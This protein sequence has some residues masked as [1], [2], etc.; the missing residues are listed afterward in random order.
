FP[1]LGL[2]LTD[3]TLA[4]ADTP[5]KPF[6]D[7]RM[8][9]LSV[10]VMPLLRKEVQMSDIRV[11]GLNLNLQRDDKGHGNWEGVGRPTQASAPQPAPSEPAPSEDTPPSQPSEKPAG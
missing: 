11:D 8:I 3:A 2:E 5:D 9:G 7:L 1:W 4:S 10:R 6:A